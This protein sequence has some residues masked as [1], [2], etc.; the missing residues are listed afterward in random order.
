MD[1][2]TDNVVSFL[3]TGLVIEDD[4]R[5]GS[6]ELGELGKLGVSGVWAVW[7]VWGELQKLGGLSTGAPCNAVSRNLS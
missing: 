1:T 3:R 5:G 4:R 2:C 7:G 6:G